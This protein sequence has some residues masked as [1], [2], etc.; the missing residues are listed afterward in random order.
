MDKII[1]IRI[2]ETL[3]S[4]LDEL[5]EKGLF[6]NRN[7]GLRASLRS[8]IYHYHRKPPKTH[9]ILAKIIANYLYMH[10][11]EVIQ[12]IYLFGSVANNTQ[13]EDSDIDLLILINRS[14]PYD[15]EM[16]IIKAVLQLLGNLNYIPSLHFEEIKRFQQAIEQ[17]FEFETNIIMKGILLQGSTEKNS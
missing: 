1:P 10:Y 4:N 7:E 5:I 13:T 6:L 16:K 17:E 8:L 12:A 9:Q 11:S 2:N 14:L 15:E 3:I